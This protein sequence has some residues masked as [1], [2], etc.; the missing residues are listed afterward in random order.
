MNK[1]RKGT[2]KMRALENYL[3]MKEKY[4]IRFLIPD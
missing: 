2:Q 4:R 3:G 1:I